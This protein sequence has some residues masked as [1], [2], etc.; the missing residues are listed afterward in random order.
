VLSLF[1]DVTEL[2]RDSALFDRVQ[3]LAHIGGWEWDAGATACT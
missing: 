2:M 3:A 1:S